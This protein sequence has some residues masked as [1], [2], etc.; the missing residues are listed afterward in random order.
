MPKNNNVPN[1]INI[2]ESDE[3]NC[4][5]GLCFNFYVQNLITLGK[6]RF[7]LSLE[8]ELVQSSVKP[9]TL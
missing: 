5:V 9:V 8:V 2:T 7:P 1:P 6:A 4:M 3:I